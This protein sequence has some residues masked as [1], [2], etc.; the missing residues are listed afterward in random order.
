MF[1]VLGVSSLDAELESISLSKD[2]EIGIGV[3][4][5]SFMIV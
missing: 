2:V 4:V 3:E 5:V 1:N